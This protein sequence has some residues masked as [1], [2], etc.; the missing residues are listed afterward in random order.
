[1]N[2]SRNAFTLQCSQEA[3]RFIFSKGYV[4]LNG[5]SLTVVDVDPQ[6]FFTVHLIPE[7]LK[8]TTFGFAQIQES[9]NLEIDYTTQMIVETIQ[10]MK[11]QIF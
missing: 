7:T 10:R 2:Q 9:M 8:R 11:L 3:L 6:G 5:V 4:A 1:V